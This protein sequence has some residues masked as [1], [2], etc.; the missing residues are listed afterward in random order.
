MVLLALLIPMAML[1]IVL[2]LSRYEELVLTP[3][4]PRGRPSGRLIKVQ[5]FTV[6]EGGETR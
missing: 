3:S 5:S 1:G 2:A 4:A 6:H